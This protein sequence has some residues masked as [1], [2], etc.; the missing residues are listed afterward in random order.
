[1][2]LIFWTRS[3]SKENRIE[4]LW[5]QFVVGDM[6]LSRYLESWDRGLSNNK[7]GEYLRSGS[8][9]GDSKRYF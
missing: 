1:M 4:K 9:R 6:Y 8:C 2:K 7:I 5:G 3:I